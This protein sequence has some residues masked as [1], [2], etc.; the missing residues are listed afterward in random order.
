MGARESCEPAACPLMPKILG[1]RRQELPSGDGLFPATCMFDLANPGG[2]LAIPSAA[3]SFDADSCIG[4]TTL[5]GDS[6]PY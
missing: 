1:G 2:Q 5:E 6:V 4:G 3:R